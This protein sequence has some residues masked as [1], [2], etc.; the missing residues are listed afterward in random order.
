[1]AELDDAPLPKRVLLLAAP[2]SATRSSTLASASSSLSRSFPPPM[3]L[4]GLPPPAPPQMAVTFLMMSPA[5]TPL[6]GL[7]AADG[8]E[9]DLALVDGGQ[10]GHHIGLF[11]RRMSPIW[12]SLVGVGLRAGWQ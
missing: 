2:A 10:H 9:G 7:L 5:L 8:Q 3:A 11:V 1:M 4:S 12:R 6:D